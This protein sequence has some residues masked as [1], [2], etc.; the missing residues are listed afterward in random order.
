MNRQW[1]AVRCVAE[2]AVRDEAVK[3]V[4]LKG[5]LAAG[6]GD[7]YADVD[8]YCLVESADLP[9]FLERRLDLLR[10]YGSLLY[11]SEADFVGP[12][13]VAVF[14]D[15]LHFD[16]YSVTPEEFPGR[17]AISI[18]YDPEN[19]LPSL[20]GGSKD[21]S[22]PWQGIH[23]HFAEFSFTLLEFHASWQRGD[24]LWSSRLASHLSG[25]LGVVL[26]CLYD[27]G[28]GQLGTKRLERYLPQGV[29]SAMRQAVADCGGPK[30]LAAVLSL[31]R[32]MRDAVGELE[33]Q[34]GAQADWALFD[35][36]EQ[37]LAQAG[38]GEVSEK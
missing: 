23:R 2:A 22:L 35:Y 1:R 12:Q 18:L 27:P 32:I 10:Q 5:S 7:E 11:H 6:S 38:S 33:E 8:L 20:A 19:R 4:F 31:C 36:M 17:G 14:A 28:N 29:L 24:M 25:D 16:L 13:V 9:A 21:H 34:H 3:A 15:G 26:R 30:T 37:T